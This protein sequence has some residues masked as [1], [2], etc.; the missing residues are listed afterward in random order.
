MLSNQSKR[1]QDNTTKTQADSHCPWKNLSPDEK[2]ER[3]GKC[4][5]DRQKSKKKYE[6]LEAKFNKV[7]KL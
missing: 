7:R 2:T 3:I 6:R 1:L 4:R 5:V